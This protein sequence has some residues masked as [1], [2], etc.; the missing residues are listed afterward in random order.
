MGFHVVEPQTVDRRGIELKNF[1]M[2][3]DPVSELGAATDAGHA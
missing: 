1:K 3:L 2:R